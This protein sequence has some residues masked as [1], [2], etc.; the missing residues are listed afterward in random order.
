MVF[1]LANGNGWCSI[2]QNKFQIYYQPEKGNADGIKSFTLS[3]YDFDEKHQTYFRKL[4]LEK[5][6]KKYKT[7]EFWGNLGAILNVIDK[8]DFSAL[9][10]ANVNYDKTY[11]YIKY[12]D[13]IY[14]T[15]ERNPIQN[16]LSGLFFDRLF[17]T[18]VDAYET[19]CT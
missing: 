7:K 18:D 2:M 8:I 10:E 17:R 4:V 13:N 14:V 15:N 12:G 1:S 5:D 11:F 3:Y 6:G 9:P 16:I 19:V